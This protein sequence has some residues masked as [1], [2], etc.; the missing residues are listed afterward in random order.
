MAV[1]GRDP[2]AFTVDRLTC[3]YGDVLAN[4]EVSLVVGRGEIFGLLGP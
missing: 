3:R 1:D 4:D 2:D